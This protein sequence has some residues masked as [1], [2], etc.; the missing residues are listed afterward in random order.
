MH[1]LFADG[2]SRGNPGPAA[3]GAVIFKGTGTETEL[4]RVAEVQ[5]YLGTA[6][7]NVAE[8]TAI[9]IGLEKAI[10]LG[11]KELQVKLD[12]ELAVKQINGQY[13]VKNAGLKPLYADVMRL[14]NQFEKITFQHVYRTDNTAADA[15]VNQTIDQALG[16]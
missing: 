6:T 10:D 13:K 1:T 16:L 4:E 8:Y 11:I 15:V 14:A 9:R 5:K 2:G 12:S 7:N 3:S